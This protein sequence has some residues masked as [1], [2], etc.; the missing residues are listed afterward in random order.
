M[1]GEL[2][3][4]ADQYFVLQELQHICLG[5]GQEKVNEALNLSDAAGFLDDK[6]VGIAACLN[7]LIN[8]DVRWEMSVLTW[9][10]EVELKCYLLSCVRTQRHVVRLHVLALEHWHSSLGNLIE[11]RERLGLGRDVGENDLALVGRAA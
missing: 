9:D 10:W 8:G 6:D 3:I 2:L 5:T 7:D 11:K 4:T 1:S